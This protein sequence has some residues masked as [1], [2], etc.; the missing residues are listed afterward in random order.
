MIKYFKSRIYIAIT[1]LIVVVIVGVFGFRFFSNYTWIDALYMTVI[2]MSTVGFGE[3]QPLDATAKLFTVFLIAT[4][5]TIFAYAVSVITEYIVNKS[6]PYNMQYRKLKKMI[7]ALND[8]IIIIGYGRNGKQAADKLLAYNK[9][10]I[11]VENDRQVIDKYQSEELLFLEGNATED[12][13]LLEAGIKTAST[14]ICTLPED[15][16]NLFIV[17]SA[18]QINKDLKIISRASQDTS[19]KKIR[20]AGADNVIMPDRIGGDHM[21]SLVVVPDLIEFL[22]NL[23]IIGKK[24][25]NIEEISFEKMFDDEQPKTIRSIDMRS[26]TGCTIIGYKS[27]EGEYVV[28]PEADTLLKPGS[29]V[30]VLG[31]PEQVNLLNKQFNI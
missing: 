8:H 22:D 15:A 13:V 19:Y 27:P 14:L 4:S 17:L 25:I 10:F 6:D 1:L 5:V 3:V 28:N 30:V 9:R 31:R 23:S 16:D 21:A 20:L 29:K 26:K 7:Q 24:S 18:R 12:E 11:I 2:T